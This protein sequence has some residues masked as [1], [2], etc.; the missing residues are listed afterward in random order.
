MH[1]SQVSPSIVA[2]PPSIAG[3]IASEAKQCVFPDPI[4]IARTEIASLRSQ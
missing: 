2:S 4:A 3:V 1:F